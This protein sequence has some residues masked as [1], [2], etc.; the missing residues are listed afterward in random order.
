MTA[1]PSRLTVGVHLPLFDLGFGFPALSGP[2]LGAVLSVVDE[3]GVQEVAAS[4]HVAFRVPWLDGLAA[5]A[6][7]AARLPGR[8]MVTA[9]C[10][11]TVRGPA[12]TA[13][14]LAAISRLAGSPLIA[15]VAA[16]SSLRDLGLAAIPAHQRWDRFEDALQ[17]VRAC[18]GNDGPKGYR[19]TYYRLD[20]PLTP[21]P[22]RGTQ[23][24]VASWGSAPGVRRAVEYGDGL[25]FSAYTADA[26]TMADAVLLAQQLRQ[27]RLATG[28]PATAFD[29]GASTCFLHVT[30]SAS[31]AQHVVETVL[32][33]FLGVPSSLLRSRT[34]VGSPDSCAERLVAFHRA[35]LGRLYVLPVGHSGEQLARLRDTVFPLVTSAD[36]EVGW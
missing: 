29:F 36:L 2:E 31:Q 10:L 8:R 23:V 9:A 25:L 16:G 17:L 4:D 33:P 5:L 14:T 27:E 34:L 21:G 6:F 30:D 11:P 32:S 15:G 19:G 26:R 22:E 28:A 35:G 3:F 20:E 18:L 1:N 7:A 24:W 13:K 12:P